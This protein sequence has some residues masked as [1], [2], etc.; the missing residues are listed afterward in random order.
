[1]SVEVEIGGLA[2]LGTQFSPHRMQPD[3]KTMEGH[4]EEDGKEFFDFSKQVNT[5]FMVMQGNF[6]NMQASVG[7]LLSTLVPP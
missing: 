6:S 2:Y 1:M 7:K 3:N 4:R 5:N